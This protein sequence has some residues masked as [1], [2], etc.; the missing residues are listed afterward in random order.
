MSD[1]S[2]RTVSDIGDNTADRQ[3]GE[4]YEAGDP[5]P[6]RLH[7]LPL[8]KGR[9][10][11][12]MVPVDGFFEGF[13]LFADLRVDAAAD[14]NRGIEVGDR[15]RHVWMAPVWQCDFGRCLSFAGRVCSHVS[16]L[17]MRRV[18]TAGPD[19]V[20]LN[21]SLSTYRALGRYTMPRV[22]QF[23]RS[24]PLCC[25]IIPSSLRQLFGPQ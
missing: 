1:S 10:N 21:R 25:H 16:G 5:Y 4:G 8:L 17:F 18:M 7:P 22:L 13:Y 9:L 12:C 20:R 15:H 24:I 14:R 2:N 3:A 23:V 19:V 11:G 6:E